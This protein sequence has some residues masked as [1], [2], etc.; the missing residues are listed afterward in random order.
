MSVATDTTDV[1]NWQPIGYVYS[2]KVEADAKGRLYQKNLL[3]YEGTDK[4]FV[5]LAAKN[6]SGRLFNVIVYNAGEKS[7]EY[8]GI[9]NVN[10][11]DNATSEVVRT[12]VYSM[13]GTQLNKAAKGLNIVKTIYADGTVKTQKVIV[14]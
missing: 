13:N 14:K 12:I 2:P 1:K 3:S 11:K 6:T 10:K 9:V 4:V 8:T 5:K 7:G